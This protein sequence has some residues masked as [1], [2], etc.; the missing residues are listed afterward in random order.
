MTD[1][2]TIAGPNAGSAGGTVS[3][4]IFSDPACTKGV[5]GA[6]SAPVTNGTSG[7]SAS[8]SSLGPGMLLLAGELQR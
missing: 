2:A 1:R 6:G 7:A 5:A 3:F 4:S 8:V